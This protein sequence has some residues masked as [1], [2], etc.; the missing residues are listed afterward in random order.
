MSAA[1]LQVYEVGG[2][3]RDRLLGLPVH[4]HDWVVVGA[5]PE[6]MTDRGFRPV[7]REFPVFLHPETGEEYALA[8]TE[9]KTGPGYHGFTFHASPS[10]S[11]TEDL[12]RRDLTINA[13]AEAPDGTIIDPFNGRGDL[14]SR[15]LRHVSDAFREDPVRILRLARFAARFAPLGFRVAGDTIALCREMVESGEVD[16]LVPERV[17]QEMAKALMAPAPD[18]FIRTLRDCGAL[19]VLFPEVDCLFGI[20]QP[21]NHHPEIDTGEH[22]LLVL[23]QAARLDGDLPARFAALVHDLGKGRTPAAELPRHRGHEARGVPLVEAISERLRVPSE[24]RDLARG[25]TRYHLHCHRIR[26]LRPQ[27]LLDMLERLDLLRRPA[28]L[29]NFL[30]ACEA[31]Y[32]GRLG[33]EDRPYPQADYLREA[34]D[35]CRAVDASRFVE[36]GLKGPAIGEAIRRV[37]LE[38]LKALRAERGDTSD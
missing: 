29:D 19:A 11:L 38:A 2:A 37:R 4:E 22:I 3:V 6:A 35:R 15:S 26:T 32:R 25:V 36:Q 27:T 5:T 14:E 16:A 18:A 31:D 21:E 12:A 1:G 30:L 10:V 33:L 17:W 7:G 8:R 13:M 9:R 23:Q 28:R 34:L 20:P 24:C